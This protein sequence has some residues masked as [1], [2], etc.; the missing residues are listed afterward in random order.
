MKERL[1]G[2]LKLRL[3]FAHERQVPISSLTT[4]DAIRE[5]KADRRSEDPL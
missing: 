3:L 2:C 4:E 5:I 1:R